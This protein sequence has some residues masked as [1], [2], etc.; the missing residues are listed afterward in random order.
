MDRETLCSLTCSFLT[1]L[2]LLTISV[3]PDLAMADP[4]AL[5]TQVSKLEQEL[6]LLKERL[7]KQEEAQRQQTIQAQPT[8]QE[9]QAEDLKAVACKT[10]EEFFGDKVQLGGLVEVAATYRRPSSGA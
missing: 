8:K 3:I 6:A 5:H 4:S 2:L 10:A 9:S 1:G 7:A